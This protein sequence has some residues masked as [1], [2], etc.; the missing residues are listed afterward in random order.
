M[1]AYAHNLRYVS[2]AKEEAYR[3][4]TGGTAA[5]TPSRIDLDLMSAVFELQMRRVM[6]RSRR[7][8]SRQ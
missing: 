7:L 6:L 3:V 2:D 5:Q 8:T 4:E 1:V